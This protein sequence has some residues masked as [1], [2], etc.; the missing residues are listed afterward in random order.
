MVGVVEVP[1]WIDCLTG[2][3]LHTSVWVH[4][5]VVTEIG[6]VVMSLSWLV[7]AE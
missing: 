6:I 4:T 5:E 2:G 1:T 7:G 3:R